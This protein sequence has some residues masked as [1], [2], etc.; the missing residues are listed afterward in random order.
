MTVSTFS[1]WVFRV[2]L[3]VRQTSDLTVLAS[4]LGSISISGKE[5]EVVAM[6]NGG[7]QKVN[8]IFEATLPPPP[9]PEEEVL[10]G[11]AVKPN[12]RADLATRER[13][14]H[15]KYEHRKYYDPTAYSVLPALQNF[16]KKKEQ[17]R[18]NSSIGTGLQVDLSNS[19]DGDFYDENDEFAEFSKSRATAS[20]GDDFDEFSKS[21]AAASVSNPRMKSLRKS[22][23]SDDIGGEAGSNSDDGDDAQQTLGIRKGARSRRVSARVSARELSSMGIDPE[24]LKKKTRTKVIR[25][26]KSFEEP[27][28]DGDE[29]SGRSSQRL[30][31]R[32]STRSKSRVR[33]KSQTARSSTES[34]SS[35]SPADNEDE[36]EDTSNDSPSSPTSP[37]SPS[38]R[39]SS[40]KARSRRSVVQRP[41]ASPTSKKSDE[42]S[43]STPE[44][45]DRA[46]SKSRPRQLKR[47]ESAGIAAPMT[48]TRRRRTSVARGLRSAQDRQKSMTS[49]RSKSMRKERTTASSASSEEDDG[50]DGAGTTASNSPTASRR[51]RCK[52]TVID[53]TRTR[54]VSALA[55]AD[56][57]LSAPV[58]PS[59]R[60]RKL[61]VSAAALSRESAKS[62]GE[63]KQ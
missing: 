45:K 26:C 2:P 15:D 30:L 13:Y 60:T 40:S 49:T 4:L 57:I 11:I 44:R 55:S 38:R 50:D 25:R 16:Q 3:N 6:E 46:R 19:D 52:S 34:P 35:P 23:S 33:S 41:P 32:G 56:D 5:K 22:R 29:R 47:A 63:V 27:P 17:S 62:R 43:G 58:T 21:R 1:L 51:R 20:K 9:T 31:R 28:T 61:R 39:R 48:P 18:M 14:I 7:N 36:D 10:G 8:A 54:G 24:E 53:G 42:D 12:N 59:R 37:A